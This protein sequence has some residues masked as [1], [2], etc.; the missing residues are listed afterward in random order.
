[1][2]QQGRNKQEINDQFLSKMY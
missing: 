2:L 1:M